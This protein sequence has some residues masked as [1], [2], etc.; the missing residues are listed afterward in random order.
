M[1]VIASATS[2]DALQASIITFAI[3]VV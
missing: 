3:F 1:S 2:R